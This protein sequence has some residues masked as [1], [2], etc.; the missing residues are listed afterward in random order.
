MK[1]FDGGRAFF[2][3]AA[4]RHRSRGEDTNLETA[5]RFVSSP[6]LWWRTPLRGVRRTSEG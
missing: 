3:R 6:Q 2:S 1:P 4:N 5:E